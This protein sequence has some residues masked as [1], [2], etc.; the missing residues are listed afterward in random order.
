MTGGWADPLQ[1]PHTVME[2]DSARD[3]RTADENLE[4]RQTLHAVA[5]ASDS[6]SDGE[7]VDNASKAGK[8]LTVRP[9]VAS[10]VQAG[11]RSIE[12]IETLG[13][14][15]PLPEGALLRETWSHM[16]R[17]LGLCRYEG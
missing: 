14:Y 2:T 7:T 3:T 16:I 17:T 1:A 11:Y 8:G 15:T 9:S 6:V 4:V 5:S 10:N 13:V 12:D